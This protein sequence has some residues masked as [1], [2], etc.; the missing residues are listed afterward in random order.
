MFR[1][2]EKVKQ[3]DIRKKVI[4]CDK[5]HETFIRN[6]FCCMAH[7]LV[8]FNIKDMKFKWRQ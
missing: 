8:H 4:W 2:H 1:G 3:K 7:V 5:Y 6:V